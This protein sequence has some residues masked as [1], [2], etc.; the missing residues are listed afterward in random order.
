MVLGFSLH[1][2]GE[3]R[4]VVGMDVCRYARPIVATSVR[5]QNECTIG[6]TFLTLPCTN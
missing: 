6:V 3:A 5:V 1:G 4:A 2:S